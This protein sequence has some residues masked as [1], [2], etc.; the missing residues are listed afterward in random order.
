M[1][2]SK[3][4]E[5]VFSAHFLHVVISVDRQMMLKVYF[6]RWGSLCVLV[7][8]NAL[9]LASKL[10]VWLSMLYRIW[11]RCQ[12]K[13]PLFVGVLR[14]WSHP[15][16]GFEENLIEKVSTVWA[17]WKKLTGAS[18]GSKAC[19]RLL[20]KRRRRR[21]GLLALFHCLLQNPWWF[22][23]EFMTLTYQTQHYGHQITWHNI[24][25]TNLPDTTL[26]TLQI[27]QPTR[28]NSFSNLLL[29]IYAQLNMF[30]ASSRPSSWAQQLQWQPL[31]LPL[32]HG[33]GSAVG[34]GRAGCPNHDQQHCH[35]HAPKVKPEAATAVVELLM[36]GR[37][38][39][40]TCWAV[41]KLQVI[42]WRN[43]GINLIDLFELYDDARTYRFKISDTDLSLSAMFQLWGHHQRHVLQ[44]VSSCTSE[45]TK[46]V[47]MLCT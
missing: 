37:R 45:S 7:N 12:R 46:I 20:Y 23:F 29:E 36:M 13:V 35:H 9:P 19:I 32:V 31:V 22:E 3:L 1:N 18:G 28:C 26:R 30:R 39:P 10:L 34:R 15:R 42:N 21:I 40:E 33:D 41:N 44:L 43:C 24:T 2:S 4:E 5:E 16:Y 6:A 11:V 38:M 25:D 47:L 14:W 27:N 8:S 17:A